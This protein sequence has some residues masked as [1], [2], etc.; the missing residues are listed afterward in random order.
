[1]VDSKLVRRSLI[2]ALAVSLV[3][4]SPVPLSACAL[5]TSKLAE[6]ATPKTQPRCDQMNMNEIGTQLV[7]ASD[8]SCCV[9]SNAPVPQLQYKASNLSLAAP[10]AVLDVT[11][12][13]PRI[14][15]LPL[16]LIVQDVSPPSVQSLLCTFLI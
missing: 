12:D 9:V 8:T 1:M 14:Q 4:L 2:F 10:V 13:T 3:G 7:A 16:V 5:L 15:H 11:G 6:C